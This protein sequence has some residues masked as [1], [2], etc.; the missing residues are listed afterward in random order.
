[1]FGREGADVQLVD[2][3]VFLAHALPAV[4]APLEVFGE[5]DRRGLMHPIRLPQRTGVWPQRP[6]I[7]AEGVA[8]SLRGGWLDMLE[9]SLSIRLHRADAVP[10]AADQYQVHLASARGPDSPGHRLSHSLGHRRGAGVLPGHR[11]AAPPGLP[12]CLVSHAR[13]R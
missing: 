10:F 1:A 4:V 8:L 12:R 5:E 13:L 11:S 2:H 6:A 3:E 7:E 9:V